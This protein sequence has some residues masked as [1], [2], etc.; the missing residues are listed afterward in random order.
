MTADAAFAFDPTPGLHAALSAQALLA[1]LPGM[2]VLVM[3]PDLQLLAAHGSALRSVLPESGVQRGC[4]L[5]H[6]D[7][8]L[9]HALEPVCARALRGE[10]GAA[11]FGLQGRWYQGRI[12]PLRDSRGQVHAVLAVCN[13]VT[14]IK[15][16]EDAQRRA[17]DAYLGLLHKAPLG[18]YVVDARLRMLHVSVGAEP[19]FA[20]VVPLLG[21]D[22]DDVMHLLWPRPFAD[23]A[24]RHF[25]H[26]LAS[27]E[28]FESRGFYERRHD[29]Q[30]VES[31][32][33][34]LERVRLPDGC[35]GVACYFYDATLRHQAEEQLRRQGER[36]A[37]RVALEDTLR[38]LG[39]ASAI[40][41][42]AAKLLAADLQAD[43]VVYGEFDDRGEQ[44]EVVADVS[45]RMPSL[46]GKLPCEAFADL[47]TALRRGERVVRTVLEAAMPAQA[48]VALPLH[49]DE[50]C[51]A[52]LCAQRIGPKGWTDEELWRIELT[53]ERTWATVL[54]CRAEAALARS[55][56]RFRS[57]VS[58]VTD[59]PWIADAEGAFATAQPAWQTYTGQT[60][61][62]HAGFGWMQ[63]VHPQDR[64]HVNGAW[65]AAGERGE[66]FEAEARLW[67]AASQRWR[68]C[69]VRATPLGTREGRIREWVGS[70]DDVHDERRVAEEL[71]EA[72]RRKDAF[73]ATLSH[74]LRNPLAP[75]RSA[76]RLM[77]M[78]GV[79]GSQVARARAIIERQTRHMSLLLDDLLDVARITQGVLLLKKQR[80]ELAPV[81]DA[82]LEVAGPEIEERRHA[83]RL[84]LPDAPVWLDGDPVRLSQV[85]ANLLT[86][87]ARYTAPG[88]RIDIEAKVVGARLH[89]EVRDN[90]D[91]LSAQALDAIF[92]TSVQ[93]RDGRERHPA[94]LGI[95][96]AI[97]RGLLELHGGSV[98]ARSAGLGCGSCFIATLPLT[99]M[100]VDGD[101]P[102]AVAAAPVDPGG[103]RRVLV[104]DDNH[105]AAEMLAGFLRLSGHD[106]D[107]AGSGLGGL[108]Q[109]RRRRPDVALLDIGMPDLDGYALARQLRASPEG[110][111]M[112]LAALTGWGQASDRRR[113]FDAGFDAHFTKPVDM[114]ELCRWI[115]RCDGGDAAGSA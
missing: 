98:Q 93:A 102:Q 65:R 47:K 74:E 111:S 110:G 58:I 10:A 27:G 115:A 55:E 99:Q 72:D 103:A 97:A 37:Y 3:D 20:N 51:V 54:R 25:R 45:P 32:D 53:A 69:R 92:S 5:R 66:G 39:D 42:A 36:D 49:K 11:G 7:P 77:S 35:L 109:A 80:I 83:L 52:L 17:S 76:A 14:E 91:G 71:R 33:W 43:R 78:P 104:V 106:V 48:L 9:A 108:E 67:H 68:T 62:A 24:V 101:Q 73:L 38:P 105:D 114:D 4:F 13:D 50:Q 12:M 96:L 34:M 85:L 21:R 86:N 60:W 63:A 56:E 88:G 82:A 112:R 100:L 41:E 29:T 59:V 18:I 107:V 75:V 113:A 44:V 57:L 8:V 79:D 22:L 15:A 28:R 40:V 31:Y 81:V 84:Q 90:G 94:G 95:G 26:T 16:C 61:T 89:L 19:V 6:V 70:C 23:E 64:D 2:M 87:A 1:G 30:A 46:G